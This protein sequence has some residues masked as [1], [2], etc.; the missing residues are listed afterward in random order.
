MVARLRGRPSPRPAG[1]PESEDEAAGS[2]PAKTGNNQRVLI[3]VT[4][5]SLLAALGTTGTLIYLTQGG[6]L[7]AQEASLQPE[8]T[9]PLLDLGPFI[10]NLGNVND[11]RY[12]RIG[13]SL[14][15]QTRDPRY[16]KAGESGQSAWLAEFKSRLKHK[17]AMF[18]DVVVTT[19]SS[20]RAED[21]GSS[22]GKE[23]LKADLISHMNQFLD[24]DADGAQV[25]D[26]Y[27]TD[28]VIQ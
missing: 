13:L 6:R 18:K 19:L 5:F 23:A 9:G 17:E 27:F 14:D 21:L 15:F 12:L 4:V 22:T 1:P 25:R 26:V 2:R 11:R 7:G 24:P 16:V 3:A 8:R 28:F 20:K 10:V